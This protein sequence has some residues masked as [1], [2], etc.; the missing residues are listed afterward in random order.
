MVFFTSVFAIVFAVLGALAIPASTASLNTGSRTGTPI[1]EGTH[2][3]FFYSWWTDGGA[4]ATYTNGPKGQFKVLA[5][6]GTYNST[7]DSYLAVHGWTQNPLIEYY[8]VEYFSGSSNPL[9]GA[10]N[11]GSVATDGSVY[12]MGVRTRV[13]QISIDG[14]GS[15]FQQFWA[16]EGAGMR[17]GA[18]HYYQVLVCE[19]YFSSGSCNMTVTDVN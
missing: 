13:N 17:L 18:G 10:I 16:W 7:G 14:P 2:D 12:D 15:T 19:G 9:I 3:G 6:T 5:Y 1:S 4:T 8:I 11:K